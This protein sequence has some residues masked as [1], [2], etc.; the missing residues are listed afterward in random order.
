M[1]SNFMS[2]S[3]EDVTKKKKIN[4]NRK[5][6]F[7][8]GK[9]FRV[10]KNTFKNNNLEV[11]KTDMT[12]LNQNHQNQNDVNIYVDKAFSG[13]ICSICGENIPKDDLKKFKLRCKHF[14]CADCYYEYIKEKINNNQ[15]L[16]IN[17]PQKDCEEI[18]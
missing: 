13:K 11:K 7:Y 10:N 8:N 14:F 15:F 12:D 18:T 16:Q 2:S 17:C 6:N 5:F 9:L 1:K 3:R 4:N